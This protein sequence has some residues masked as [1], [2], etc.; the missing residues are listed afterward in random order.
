MNIDEEESIAHEEQAQFYIDLEK[1]N[2]DYYEMIML[3]I[4]ENLNEEL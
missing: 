3:Q 1:A 2:H 4:E